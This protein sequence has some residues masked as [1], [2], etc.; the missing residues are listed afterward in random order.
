MTRKANSESTHSTHSTST[1]GRSHAGYDPSKFIVPGR[2]HHGDS[3]REWCRVQPSTDHEVDAIIAS[4]KWPFRTKGD[5]LRWA[6]WEGVKRINTMESVPGN[7]INVAETIIETCRASEIWMRFKTSIDATETMVK[8][9]MEAGNESEAL[10]LLSRVRAEA[11]KLE[12]SGWRD[13]YM[14]E[15][16]KRFGHIWARQNKRSVGLGRAE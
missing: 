2:D 15:F 8:T 7:M 11:M 10:K 16:E 4:K 6:I 12:E 13:Q 3:V 5:F 1:N 9:F 14:Q